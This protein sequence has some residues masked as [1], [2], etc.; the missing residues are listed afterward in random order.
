MDIQIGKYKRPGVFVEYDDQSLFTNPSQG[1]LTSLILG[2]SKKGPFNTPIYL[3]NIVDR[4]QIFGTLDRNL[5]RK[6]SYFHRTIDK[7][8]ELSPVYAINLL[9]TDDNLDV[10][11][12]KS[13]STKASLANSITTEGPYRRV[14]DTTGFWKR[15]EQ[16]FLTMANGVNPQS[17][18]STRLL[19]FTNVSGNPVTVFIFKTRM[20]G[21]D[22]SLIEW[23]GSVEKMPPYLNAS[24]FASDYMVDVLIVGGDWSDY[25][26]L[27]ADGRWSNYFSKDGLIKSQVDNFAYDK[28]VNTLRFYEGLSLIPYFRDTFGNNIFLEHRINA[29]TD[30]TGLFCSFNSELFESTDGYSG[31]IDLIGNSITD[32][33]DGEVEFLSYKFQLGET[34]NYQLTELNEVGN[35]I[36]LDDFSSTVARGSNNSEFNSDGFGVSDNGNDLTVVTTNAYIIKSGVKYEV[37]SDIV[38]TNNN[39][40]ITPYDEPFE[41]VLTLNTAGEFKLYNSGVVLETDFII[42]EIEFDTTT[43][44]TVVLKK[45]EIRDLYTKTVNNGK[46]TLDFNAVSNLSY[47]QTQL[48]NRVFNILNI[49]QYNRNRVAIV[50]ANGEKVSMME[51]GFEVNTNSG[52]KQIIFEGEHAVDI[53]ALY[54]S[55]NE[56]VYDNTA[57]MTTKEPNAK[58]GY[59][60]EFYNDYR[61]GIIT[62]GDIFTDGTT[63]TDPVVMYMEGNDLVVE[64][65]TLETLTL[66]NNTLIVKSGVSNFQQT[67]DIIT[68]VA[69]YEESE[70]RILILANRYTEVRV[71][72]FLETLREDPNNPDYTPERNVARILSKRVYSGNNA[73]VEIATDLPINKV[74]VGSTGERQVKRFTK[75]EDYVTTYNGIALG[76][77]NVRE[78]S[79]PN[80]TEERQNDILNVVAQG[81]HL[82]KAITNK[83]TFDFRYLI[84]SFGL[85]LTENSKQQL[86]DICGK[87]LDCFG[88]LNM[89]SV[90]AFRNSSSP[91]FVDED[92][93]INL[94]YI[95][96]GANPE[97]NPAFNYSFASGDGVTAVGYFFPYVKVNSDGVQ[98][99]VPPAMYVANTYL[100]KHRNV[101]SNI[102]PW[103]IAAGITNGR[104]QG[105]S[106]IEL[107]L[108]GED[109]DYMMAG[110]MNPIVWK[111]NRGFVIESE[112]TA[113]TLYNSTLG[114][115]HVREV[116]IEL[117]R[118]LSAMLLDFQW[119]YNTA[120]IR[121]EIKLRADV[122][123]QN[124]VTKKGLYAFFNKCDEENNPRELIENEIGLLSTYVEPVMGLKILV[125]KITI[126]RNGTIESA[127]FMEQFQ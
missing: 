2:F 74:D 20:T 66:V 24:D 64:T 5:E 65:L 101:S 81:T 104:I 35:V 48:L 126:L 111:R 17:I 37:G 72:D 15:D 63:E 9:K 67:M 112:N 106:G 23:Y 71:G 84:D 6:G 1:G 46:T 40:D 70:N 25:N 107:E 38:V 14:Y 85:G 41:G 69:G 88:F 52:N 61:N 92:G 21:F 7:T 86:S 98:I 29:D 116:L 42:G 45:V 117:E 43:P 87:R 76:G 34:V 99:E 11:K 103:T 53:V 100:R 121:A 125:N 93:V 8:L 62:S 32:K 102:T 75:I 59:D 94:E 109:I 51:T 95:S 115:I 30:R 28:N 123:C 113:L 119:K 91:S 3:E 19:H 33:I 97:S 118:E 73:Y 127:G 120:E 36:A 108:S 13:I 39:I 56:F 89:P 77:F 68:G 79:M 90:R 47:G 31:A 78:E 4:E 60:S 18:D 114:S 122:I 16:A 44:G 57:N 110:K 124:F 22:R 50:L 49:D 80:G 54:F 26:R 58:I 83:E 105:I 82:F 27:S 12:Y 10:V 96:L 55:D